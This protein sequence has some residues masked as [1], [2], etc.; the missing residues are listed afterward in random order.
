LFIFLFLSGLLRLAH[1]RFLR[2]RLL[3]RMPSF[4]L[5]RL[6]FAL[7]LRGLLPPVHR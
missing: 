1:L 7:V 3:F 6:R 2:F 5:L 4:S